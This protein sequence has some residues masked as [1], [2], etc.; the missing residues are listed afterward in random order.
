MAV[1]DVVVT[2]TA[3]AATAIA[4]S[5]TAA[6]AA[7]AATA[8]REQAS[9]RRAW[10]SD[11]E[12]LAPA[13]MARSKVLRSISDLLI[14]EVLRRVNSVEHFCPGSPTTCVAVFR[15]SIKKSGSEPQISPRQSA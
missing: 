12:P 5:A 8:E 15:A 14:F 3:A 2:T 11:Q 1:V 10:S 9:R 6:A 13:T 4:G 7:A